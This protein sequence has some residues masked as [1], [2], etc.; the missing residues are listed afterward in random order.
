MPDVSKFRPHTSARA[1]VS[2]LCDGTFQSL[3][4]IR[5]GGGIGRGGKLAAVNFLE[6]NRAMG[7]L[8]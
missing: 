1:T 5:W 3:I 4:I 6:K 7:K 2:R 8:R